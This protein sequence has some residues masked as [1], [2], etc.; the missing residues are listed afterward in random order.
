M[1]EFIR[2]SALSELIE[3]KGIVRKIEEDEIALVKLEGSVFAFLNV[4]PHQHTP[5]IDKYG[6]Q[7]AGNNL[8]C[9]MHGWTYDLKTG[10]CLNVPPCDIPHSDEISIMSGKNGRLKMLDIKIEDDDVFV[11]KIVRN[12]NW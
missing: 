9:P 10:N 6:G 4:C 11:R 3:N 2:V 1:D 12:L 7:I 5:L 8:T